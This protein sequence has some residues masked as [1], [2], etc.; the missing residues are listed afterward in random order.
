MTARGRYYQ[1]SC[2][3]ELAG[4]PT[5]KLAPRLT[6][7]PPTPPLSI[8]S[9]PCPHPLGSESALHQDRLSRKNSNL[10]AKRVCQLQALPLTLRR[11]WNNLGTEVFMWNRAREGGLRTIIVFLRSI[12]FY[13]HWVWCSLLPQLG[14]GTRAP[15]TFLG[16]QNKS[17]CVNKDPFWETG[18]E[19][20]VWL[21]HWQSSGGCGLRAT[22]C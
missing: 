1:G 2:N 6:I 18:L 8:H 12:Q 14:Q 21:C 22:G 9:Y 20:F 4:G 16:G 11:T 3:R 10:F 15:W 19:H 5:Q 17:E 7:V 13:G